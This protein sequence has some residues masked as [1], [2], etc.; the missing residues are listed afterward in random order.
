[1]YNINNFKAV[2]HIVL[3]SFIQILI[4]IKTRVKNKISFSYSFI[5]FAIQSETFS[6]WEAFDLS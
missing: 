6:R 3:S 4:L 2:T 5:S 1:M